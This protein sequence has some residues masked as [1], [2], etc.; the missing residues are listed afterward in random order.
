MRPVIWTHS[1]QSDLAQIDDWYAA[2][3]PG[4]ADEVGDRAIASGRFLAEFPSAGEF[5][6]DLDLRKWRVPGTNY[7]LLYRMSVDG[8]EILR[9]RHAREDWAGVL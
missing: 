5:L 8:V 9:L 4:F 7:I 1:A 2:I 6:P 3:N